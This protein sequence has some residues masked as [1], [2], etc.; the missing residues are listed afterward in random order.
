MCENHYIKA[1]VTFDPDYLHVL[2]VAGTKHVTV[3]TTSNFSEKP[4]PLM[5]LQMLSFT[6]SEKILKTAPRNEATYEK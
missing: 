4:K 2:S 6:E 5:R 1:I 3:P